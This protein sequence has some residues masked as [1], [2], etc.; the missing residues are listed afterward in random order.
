[1]ADLSV[2][3]RVLDLQPGASMAEVKTAWRDLAQVWHPDRFTG[4]ERLQKKAEEALKEINEAYRRLAKSDGS[5]DA[6]RKQPRYQPETH[7]AGAAETTHESILAEGV[8]AWN[9]WRK[10]YMDVA[11]RL[12]GAW[13]ARRSLE[14]IDLREADLARVNFEGADLYKSN[15]SGANFHGARLK[16]AVLHRAIALEADFAGADFT[17]ADL[18]SADLRGSTFPRARFDGANLLGARFDGA[19][20]SGALGLT[21]AQLA[22]ALFDAGTKLPG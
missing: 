7:E 14:G 11:P 1:M 10:K 22:A 2:Y 19:D 13:L 6:A 16:G 18:S 15:G 17:G 20:L 4:N 3:Y 5:A 9:L 21:D 12:A 8:A